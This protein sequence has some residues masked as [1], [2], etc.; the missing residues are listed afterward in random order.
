MATRESR[1]AYLI[2]EQIEK[3]F[4]WSAKTFMRKGLF[5]AQCILLEYQ[6]YPYL[7]CS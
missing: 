6:I 4:W 5:G 3:F 1:H 7:G 2:S